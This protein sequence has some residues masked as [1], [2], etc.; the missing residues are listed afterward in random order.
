MKLSLI[1]Y[2]HRS[3]SFASNT[4][5][6]SSED[7]LYENK[8]QF[9]ANNYVVDRVQPKRSA[10]RQQSISSIESDVESVPSIVISV[11]NDGNQTKLSLIKAKNL[12][13]SGNSSND[14]MIPEGVFARIFPSNTF[15]QESQVKKSDEFFETNLVKSK[16]CKIIKF[17]ENEKFAIDN[18]QFP[19]R[20][21]LYECDKQKMRFSIGHSILHL[22]TGENYHS[23]QII[24]LDL[25]QTIYK[26]QNVNQVYK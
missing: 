17:N 18:Q 12:R 3:N 14:K 11:V 8:P 20:I 24:E 15:S 1:L 25:F 16:K 6:D 13:R 26:A 9:G 23:N 10:F 4:D 7:V 21:S 22:N 5:S 19:I 2:S